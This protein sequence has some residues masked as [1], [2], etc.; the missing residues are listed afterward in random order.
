MSFPITVKTTAIDRIAATPEP[1]LRNLQITQCYSELSVAFAK[2]MGSMANWCSF[3]TWA[4]KQAGQTIRKQDLQQSLA[5]LLQKEPEIEVALSLVAELAKQAGAKQRLDQLRQS[6]F[7]IMLS[8][9]ANQAGEAVS[10]GNKKVFEEIAREFA[11]FM[12][13]CFNDT[14]Y[15]P[16]YIDRF[17]ES[18]LP[19]PAPGGQDYLRQAFRGYYLA[20]FETDPQQKTELNLL[21]NLQIGF[22]EQTRLQPE[23]AEALNASFDAQELKTQLLEEL[24]AG[25]S[26]RSRFMGWMK[27]LVGQ[28]GLLDKAVESLLQRVQFHLRRALT[29]HLMTLTIPPD[30]RL[31]LGHDLSLSYPDIL[32]QL[33]NT[34]LLALLQQTDPTPGS[35]LE[36]GAEDWASLPERM[37]FIGELFRCCHV[38]PELFDAPFSPAQVEALR[39]GK[40]PEGSM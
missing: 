25:I 28:T 11:R 19:G 37:H 23:I 1:V 17:C 16:E 38:S 29:L 39:L 24:R 5:A 8:S 22:H 9:A 4:S 31:R 14:S 10:R 12:S 36:S 35:L 33:C 13:E 3:A 15:D 32:K 40:I 6:A 21:A 2:Q 30:R 34:D 27:Q 7:G 18:L 20:L 26:F